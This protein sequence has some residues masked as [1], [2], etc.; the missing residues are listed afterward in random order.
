M[1]VMRFAPSAVR[2]A[3]PSQSRVRSR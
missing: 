3:L 1:C 2:R